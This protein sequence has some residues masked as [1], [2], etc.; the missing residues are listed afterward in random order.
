MGV[1]LSRPLDRD[2]RCATLAPV[3][4]P[5]VDAFV[6]TLH[7]GGQSSCIPAP[8]RRAS[9]RSHREERQ[10]RGAFVLPGCVDDG[11]RR[12]LLRRGRR[13]RREDRRIERDPNHRDGATHPQPAL[14]RQTAR[15]FVPPRGASPGGD[16]GSHGDLRATTEALRAGG[17]L[18]D[19]NK[20]CGGET[21]VVQVGDQLD[22]GS[23]EIAILFLLERLRFEARNA[24]EVSSS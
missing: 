3:W 17:V 1:G 15:S 19:E 16:R 20:W 22:R 5:F 13:R 6:D 21:T 12:V 23:D 11:D 10:P 7:A 18:D 8:A 4:S 14:A 2:P 9:L 24:P